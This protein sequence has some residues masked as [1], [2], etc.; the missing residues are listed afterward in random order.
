M[1]WDDY[2]N[3]K[4]ICGLIGAAFGIV[5]FAVKRLHEWWE[6]MHANDDD[7]DQPPP[8]KILGL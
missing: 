6:D 8:G 1:T 4:L 2:W 7:E 3:F 5:I